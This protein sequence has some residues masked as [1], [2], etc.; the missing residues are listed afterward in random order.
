MQNVRCKKRGIPQSPAVTAPFRARGPRRRRQWL[1]YGGLAVFA[2]VCII[3]SFAR[4][5]SVE[6][7]TREVV[8]EE[9]DTLWGIWEEVGC[10]NYHKWKYEVQKMN[11]KDLSVLRPHSRIIVP[12]V[13]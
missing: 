8:V 7:T 11:D 2:A 1:W 9:G 12:T 13:K 3:T 6:Y 5:A 4:A 10:G